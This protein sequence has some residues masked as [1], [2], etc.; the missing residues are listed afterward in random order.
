MITATFWGAESFLFP[1]FW[2]QKYMP[3]ICCIWSKPKNES[4]TFF[5]KFQHSWE[6]FK[7]P[8]ALVC[9][10]LVIIIIFLYRENFYVICFFA[11]SLTSHVPQTV[12]K[13]YLEFIC[14]TLL[15]FCFIWVYS[16]VVFFWDLKKKSFS[17]CWG[18]GGGWGVGIHHPLQSYL[19]I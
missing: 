12:T 16:L 14:C 9:N 13:S 18:R 19:I 1:I 7:W 8:F 3:H 10:F 11:H 6:V 17:P 15:E 5:K 4:K 2:I